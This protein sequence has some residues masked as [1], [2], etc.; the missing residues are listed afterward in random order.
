MATCHADIETRNATCRAPATL[1]RQMPTSE[2]LRTYG[3]LTLAVLLVIAGTL[4]TGLLPSTALYQ[5][6]AGGVIVAGFALV[7]VCLGGLDAF[8]GFE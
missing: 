8:D 7:F 6:L 2:K 5:V 1:Y 3:C 4:A